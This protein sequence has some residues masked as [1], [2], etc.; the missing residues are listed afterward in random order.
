MRFL[1]GLRCENGEISGRPVIVSYTISK[2]VGVFDGNFVYFNGL[3][4]MRIRHSTTQSIRQKTRGHCAPP[5]SHKTKQNY[6]FFNFALMRVLAAREILYICTCIN[7][8]FKYPPEKTTFKIFFRRFHFRLGWIT[9]Q[10]D[11]DE[12]IM[13]KIV[14]FSANSWNKNKKTIL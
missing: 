5:T 9:I 3:Q 6:A 10:N 12:S 4:I 11:Y 1:S 14:D 7:Q 13:S 2:T 8:G